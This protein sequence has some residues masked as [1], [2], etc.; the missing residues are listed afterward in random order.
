MAKTPRY[1]AQEDGSLQDTKTTKTILVTEFTVKQK[2]GSFPKV[3]ITNES[4]KK[5]TIARWN[6]DE[7]KYQFGP[8]APDHAN[9]KH[10]AKAVTSSTS[11]TSVALL[12]PA[13][14]ANAIS[15]TRE[16]LLGIHN[17]LQSGA[18][19]T[20]RKLVENLRS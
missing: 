18:D 14:P 3:T 16:E 7:T 15:M 5:L 19:A 9:G 20:L 8:V 11:S 17:A 2:R 6:I 13:P 1:I 4:G 12:A 10:R